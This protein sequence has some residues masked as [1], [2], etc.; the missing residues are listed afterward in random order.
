MTARDP[1]G[2]AQDVLV[3][4]ETTAAFADVLLARRLA[5]TSL[6]AADRALATDLVYGTLAWQGRLDHHLAQLVH[7]P[8]AALDPPVRAA[9]R[10]GLYQLLF[11]GGVADHA[12]VNESVE[13]AKRSS[14]GGASLVNAVLRRATREGPGIVAGLDDRTPAAAALRHSMPAWVAERWWAE[15]GG[16]R[17][18]ALLQAIN[19]P[20]ESALRANT[21][22]ATREEVLSR[23]PVPGR[24]AA[25]LPEGI[26]LEAPFDVQASPLFEQGAVMP[27]AR[28]SMLVARLLDPQPG[29]RVLDLCAAPGAKATHLAALM[30]GQGELVAVER[31]PGRA[32]ALERTC[33]RLGA[34]HVRVEVR[35]AAEPRSGPQFQRVLVDPPCSGLGTVQSRPDIRWRASPASVDELAALQSRIL[36]A[37]AATTAP[38]GT[39]AYSVCTISRAEGEGVVDAFLA[40]HDEF[41]ADDLGAV[42]PGWRLGDTRYLQSLPDRD[43]TD[44]FFIARLRRTRR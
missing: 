23:L 34:E 33:A 20:A 13:L 40:R 21:L 17:A 43:G 22:R 9:L 39:I 27:Q 30:G 37:A 24:A 6:P 8:I 29:E 11:L 28:A 41:D 18:R 10:L 31:H 5:G 3:R 26:V 14:R 1:R 35:D 44:G 32:Q 4:V 36:D 12:A 42:Q 15:L 7:R 25:D 16:Q 2:V 38:G 19:L